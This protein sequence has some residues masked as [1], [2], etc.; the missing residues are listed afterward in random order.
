MVK[1]ASIFKAAPGTDNDADT[2]TD[3]ADVSQ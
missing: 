1:L 2:N 3:V